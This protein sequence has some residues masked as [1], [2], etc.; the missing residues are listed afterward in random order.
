MDPCMQFRS[1]KGLEKTL[2]L[3]ISLKRILTSSS[4]KECLYNSLLWEKLS[5]GMKSVLFLTF[6]CKYMIHVRFYRPISIPPPPKKDPDLD[7][8]ASCKRGI[9]HF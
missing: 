6:P 8:F 7:N 2:T 1:N 9:C 3:K 5:K 4:V